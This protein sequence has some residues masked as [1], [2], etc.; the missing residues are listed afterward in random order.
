MNKKI[1]SLMVGLVLLMGSNVYAQNENWE[2]FKIAVENSAPPTINLSAYPNPLTWQDNYLTV[3]GAKTFVGLRGNSFASLS[4]NNSKQGFYVQ[5]KAVQFYDNF[6]FKNFS[7]STGSVIYFASTGL[8]YYDEGETPDDEDGG[9]GGDE[10]WIPLPSPIINFTSATF[11]FSDNKAQR[12]GAIYAVSNSSAY[13]LERDSSLTEIEGNTIINFT[14]SAVNFSNNKATKSGGAIYAVKRQ[15][16]FGERIEGNTIINFTS[17]VVNFSNN[18]ATTDPG[19]GIDHGPQQGNIRPFTYDSSKGGAIFIAGGSTINF[20][21]SMVTFSNNTSVATNLGAGSI[22]NRFAGGGRNGGAIYAGGGNGEYS[23]DD[24]DYYSHADVIFMNSVVNFTNNATLT[25][26]R[27]NG[28]DSGG[29][30]FGGN[31]DFTNSSVTFTNNRAQGGGAIGGTKKLSFTGSTVNFISNRADYGGVITGAFSLIDSVLNFTDN[32]ANYL[33]GA[34]IGS[35][36][37]TSSAVSFTNNRA[38]SGGAIWGVKGDYGLSGNLMYLG[39]EGIRSRYSE[40]NFIGNIASEKGG[41]IA[42]LTLYIPYYSVNDDTAVVDFS[43]GTVNFI[44]NSA[45]YGGAIH[46]EGSIIIIED[47]SF[48]GNTADIAG[49]AVFLAPRFEFDDFNP[50]APLI[51]IGGSTITIR[52]INRDAVFSNNKAAGLPNDIFATGNAEFNFYAKEGRRIDLQGGIKVDEITAP[53]P[54]AGMIDDFADMRYTLGNIKITKGGE[55]ELIL[56]GRNKLRGELRVEE[57]QITIRK[58]EDF[59]VDLSL[60]N[61]AAGATYSTI[62]DNASQ[63]TKVVNAT[64]DGTVELDVNFTNGTADRL[65]LTGNF[66]GTGGFSINGFGYKE[67]T[68]V[69]I[70]RSVNGRLSSERVT[71]DTLKYEID[72]AH[73][74]ANKI[75]VKTKEAHHASSYS[76]IENGVPIVIDA[77]INLNSPLNLEDAFIY[78]DGHTFSGAGATVGIEVESGR[79]VEIDAVNFGGFSESAIKADGNII[80]VNTGNKSM[81]FKAN[82]A[83]LDVSGGAT[84]IPITNAIELR[85]GIKGDGVINKS[86]GQELKLG[87][88]VDFAGSV[89]VNNGLLKVAAVSAKISSLI[90]NY[91]AEFEMT[92]IQNSSTTVDMASIYGTIRVGGGFDNIIR[93]RNELVLGAGVDW[94]IVDLGG[95]SIGDEVM[96]IDFTG[97][98]RSGDIG[99]QSFSYESN[100][101]LLSYDILVGN[102]GAGFAR[103]GG[104]ESGDYVYAVIRGIDF[105]TIMSS[106]SLSPVFIGNAIR[107]AAVSDNS[108]IYSN[109]NERVWVA[110]Q[111]GGGSL[112]DDEAGNFDNSAAGAKAGFAFVSKADFSAGV[113]AGFASRSYK[114]GDNKATASDMDFGLYSGLGLGGNVNLAAFVGYGLQSINAKNAGDKADF[115]ATIIKFGAKAEYSAGLISPFIGFE[116][117]VVDVG[118]ID[119]KAD[120]EGLKMDAATYTRLSSQ[121]GA[122]IGRNVGGFSWFGKA[123]VDLLLAGAKPEYSVKPYYENDE[124]KTKAAKSRT[125]DSTE[126][127]AASFGLGAGLSIPVSGAVDIFASAET[128]M[129]A[130]FFGY[131][132]NIGASFKF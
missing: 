24:D 18:T 22:Y 84:I 128:K 94:N 42:I 97:A 10:A 86:G 112:S 55:G 67:N 57:G 27:S 87:G 26:G 25:L 59:D 50:D 47:P 12:G 98:S 62:D 21:N 9:Y 20:T 51:M 119:L 5:D 7:A 23:G 64:I 49:G 13:Y 35:F 37:S 68:S 40:I 34:N 79:I 132:G 29:A 44:N 92:N 117:A 69:E 123:Y 1:K 41:A 43:S 118:D 71:L 113:F 105:T 14:R 15:G 126:E 46:N 3:G 130:D 76:E 108:P 45:P 99:A 61:V 16:Q 60:L 90:V 33:G 125:I 100:G 80:I 54:G 102:S 19:S 2:N 63:E 56:S 83:D 93:V 48:M 65:V 6:E 91:G 74:N 82:G 101:K 36:N 96:I 104:L 58:G 89:N 131:Q 81:V 32:Q 124:A 111:F 120:G 109:V 17:S 52:S 8:A 127:S 75:T 110:G 77:D 53:N 39:Y 11:K 107:Q 28:A 72:A 38:K 73:S 78:G 85:S 115:D 88:N 103:S 116:G 70:A 114:Q 122:K 66:A 31:I 30:I 106:I 95:L 129:N 121:I 4:G